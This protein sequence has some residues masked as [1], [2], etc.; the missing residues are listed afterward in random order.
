MLSCLTAEKARKRQGDGGGG[1]QVEKLQ[2][3]VPTLNAPRF[4]P[5]RGPD[6]INLGEPCPNVHFT[7]FAGGKSLKISFQWLGQDGNKP[8]T[9]R[10]CSPASSS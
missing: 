10:L 8:P 3:T 5:K 2:H 7:R 9:T 4:I 1:D 6:K